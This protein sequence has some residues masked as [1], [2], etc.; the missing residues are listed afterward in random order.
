MGKQAPFLLTGA[1]RQRAKRDLMNIK[2][3]EAF[4]KRKKFEKVTEF[5][6]LKVDS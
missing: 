5:D 2:V 4:N 3:S 1:G 6:R